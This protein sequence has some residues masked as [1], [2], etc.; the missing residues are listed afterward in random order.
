M[1]TLT[2]NGQPR[3]FD[4]LNTVEDLLDQLKLDRRAVVVEVNEMVVKR[5]HIGDTYL[6]EN[7]QV[8]ILRFV[9]GG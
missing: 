1:L 6:Q 2:I 7:D 9:G 8:E 3:T 5:S 4:Y